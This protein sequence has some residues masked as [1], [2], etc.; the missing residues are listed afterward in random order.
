MYLKQTLCYNCFMNKTK[1]IAFVVLI[2]LVAVLALLFLI[3]KKDVFVSKYNS[4]AQVAGGYAS[5][6]NSGSSSGSGQNE[7]YYNLTITKTG[8]G[9]G[10]VSPFSGKTIKY[11]KGSVVTITSSP[12]GG[13]YRGPW[14]GCDSV[15]GG[16]AVVFPVSS[17]CTVTMNSDRSVNAKINKYTSINNRKC[18]IINK[19]EYIQRISESKSIPADEKARIISRILKLPVNESGEGDKFGWCWFWSF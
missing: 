19:D 2:V 14:N 13:S 18:E 10:T 17:T 15:A 5:G 16:K 9:S 8:N 7:E 3:G 11:R 6:S 12:Q 4:L 1:L